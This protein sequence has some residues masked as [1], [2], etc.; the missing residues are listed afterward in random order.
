LTPI[1][2]STIAFDQ[3][4]R[5]P[6][7]AVS[8][9]GGHPLASAGTAKSMGF[10]SRAIRL[11]PTPRASAAT[12]AWMRGAVGIARTAMNLGVGPARAEN[13]R[14]RVIADRGDDRR[15]TS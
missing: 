8:H 6:R 12:S 11:R 13:V 7:G 2:A 4:E 15:S 14:L 3:V 5:G 9:G 10:V 1:R